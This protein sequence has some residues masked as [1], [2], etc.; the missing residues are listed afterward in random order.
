MLPLT[1]AERTALFK[2]QN[3]AAAI[4]AAKLAKETQKAE[5][6]LA[7]K[8][9]EE[10]KSA[11]RAAR[12]AGAAQSAAGQDTNGQGTDGLLVKLSRA[13]NQLLRHRAAS[14]GVAW[15]SIRDNAAWSSNRAALILR[16]L[17]KR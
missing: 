15:S 10:E 7:K 8:K 13:M 11:K 12:A 2:S 4:D 6:K 17:N 3:Q 14:E 1:K 5:E 16:R 9:K